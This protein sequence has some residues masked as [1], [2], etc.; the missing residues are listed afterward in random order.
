[1]LHV[2]LC[3]FGQPLGCR[4][5]HLQR[6]GEYLGR[7]G[8][9]LGHRGGLL[10][11]RGGLLWRRGGYLG[12]CG[13]YLGRPAV[14]SRHYGDRRKSPRLV[15]T[16]GGVAERGL[17]GYGCDDGGLSLHALGQCGHRTVL[18]ADIG[19]HLYGVLM[20]LGDGHALEDAGAEGA[21]KRVAGA[22]GVGNLHMRS[23]VERLAAGSEDIAAVHTTGEHEHVQ[24][25]LAEDEPALVLNVQTGVA[26]EAAQRD[27]LFIVYLQYIATLQTLADNLLGIEILAEIDIKDLETVAGRVVEK[28]VDGITACSAALGQ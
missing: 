17:M 22:H 15:A 18:G 13:G 2:A 4:G 28:L 24:I 1:M 16:S 3:A 8:G 26:E 23:L 12:R 19:A 6:R 11:R 14:G 9:Y 21:G 27:E 7:R 25:V 20:C 5:N 10:W